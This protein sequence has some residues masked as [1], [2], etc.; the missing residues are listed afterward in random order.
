MYSRSEG[1]TRRGLALGR[2]N[3]VVG[4]KLGLK[5]SSKGVGAFCGKALALE[6]PV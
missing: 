2:Q 1:V 4:V 5:G 6:K 3:R